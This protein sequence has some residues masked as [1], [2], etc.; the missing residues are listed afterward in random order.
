MVASGIG[1][2]IKQI[3]KSMYSGALKTITALVRRRILQRNR[4]FILFVTA[5]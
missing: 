5:L 4:N 1:Q 2:S 3:D